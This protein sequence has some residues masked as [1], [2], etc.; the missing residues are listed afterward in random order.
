MLKRHIVVPAV[1]AMGSNLGDREATLLAATRELAD[2][3]G[4][5]LT[6]VSSL[7]ETV[8][9]KPDGPDEAAP[10]YLNAVALIRTKLTPQELLALLHR[11]EA[12]HGRERTE[13]WGDRTLDLDLIDVAGIRHDADGLTLPH[14]RAAER[15]FVLRPW[16]EVDPDAVLRG[17]GRVDELLA[18]LPG[19]GPGAGPGSQP[20]AGEPR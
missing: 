3:E 9:L 17:H 20:G 13:H 12:D 4:V 1:V 6:A 10:A 2:A 7:H 16:L 11:I 15:E 14:P 8:A 19:A 5:E 18:G